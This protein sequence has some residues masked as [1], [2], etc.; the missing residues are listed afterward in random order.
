MPTTLGGMDGFT[1]VAFLI[2]FGLIVALVLTIGLLLR[3]RARRR[4]DTPNDTIRAGDSADANPQDAA[5]RA[6]GTNAWMR[7][8]GGGS[9]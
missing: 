7:P 5:R 2:G 6:Q 4:A 8:G 1:V 3:V 9:F